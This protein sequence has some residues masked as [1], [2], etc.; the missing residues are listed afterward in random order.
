MNKML[1]LTGSKVES[2]GAQ[3]PEAPPIIRDAS[4]ECGRSSDT[5]DK[6]S[7]TKQTV[8]AN[9]RFVQA[10]QV[11]EGKCSNYDTA[12]AIDSSVADSLYPKQA[13]P[14]PKEVKG[15][16]A[17]QP[18]SASEPLEFE[19]DSSSE[20]NLVVSK[21][22]LKPGRYLYIAEGTTPTP[23]VAALAQ[24]LFT[25]IESLLRHVF[26]VGCEGPQFFVYYDPNKS[27]IAF[28]RA[29][30]LWFNAA[31]EVDVSG[32]KNAAYGFGRFWFL[33]VCHELAHN[34]VKQHNSRFADACSAITLEYADRFKA[35]AHSFC[36]SCY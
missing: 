32:Y 6:S 20:Q 36:G 18:G 21:V 5:C 26:V 19:L 15:N 13:T 28:N 1:A 33:V 8:Q 16:T 22:E 9:V 7:S 10:P 34:R 23:E 17:A 2:L 30:Q 14:A 11:G 24:Q 4:M 27:S 3:A 12:A 35:F 31:V 25:S 29:G